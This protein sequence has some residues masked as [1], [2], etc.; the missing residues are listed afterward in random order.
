MKIICY[1]FTG[2]EKNDLQ[3]LKKS[4]TVFNHLERLGVRIERERETSVVLENDKISIECTDFEDLKDQLGVINCKL[5]I[6]SDYAA[7]L[8]PN[9]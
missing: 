3:V 5:D 4:S 6:H 9:D 1:L 7:Q 2:I 8:V